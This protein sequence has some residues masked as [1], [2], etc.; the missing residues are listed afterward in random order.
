MNSVE[1]KNKCWEEIDA[2]TVRVKRE[3]VVPCLRKVI[4]AKRGYA[5]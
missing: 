3:E 1:E 5:E 4:K 2:E